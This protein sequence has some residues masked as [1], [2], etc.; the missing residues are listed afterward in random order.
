MFRDHWQYGRWSLA[1]SGLSW[2][3]GNLYYILIPAFAG[4]QAAGALKAVA[5]LVLPILHFN[6]ALASLL[7]PA[8]AAAARRKSHFNRLVAAGLA[9]FAGGSILYWAVLTTFRVPIVAALYGQTYNDT[10][11]LIPI[12]ALLPLGAGCSAVLGSALRAL[13]RPHQVSGYAVSTALTL[14]VG[15]WGVYAWGLT[16]AAL[17]LLLSSATTAVV[18]SVFLIGSVPPGAAREPFS[19]QPGHDN[20]SLRDR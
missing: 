5:N 8:L 17:G 7:L 3:P 20:G 12:M 16:G 15:I 9:V 10:A 1:S 4:L 11:G 6:S 14:T 13:E 18:C 2:I 19:P